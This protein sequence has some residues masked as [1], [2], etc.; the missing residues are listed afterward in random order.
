MKQFTQAVKNKNWSMKNLAK[1]WD[2]SPRQMSN[3]ADNPKQIH[4][5]ALSGLPEFYDFKVGDC[6]KVISGCF[7]NFGGPITK[8]HNDRIYVDLNIFSVI[9][10]VY[11]TSDMLIISSDYL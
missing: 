9:T 3:I 6:V 1:R 5:D 10:N 4:W 2:I 8:I 11:F 7:L